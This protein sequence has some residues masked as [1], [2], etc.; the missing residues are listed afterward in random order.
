LRR[1]PIWWIICPVIRKANNG[2]VWYEFEELKDQGVTQAFLTRLGGASAPPFD[3]L[4]LGHTVGDDLAAVEENHDRAFAAL[5]LR[6]E[7]I[8][9]PYQV[10]GTHVR[11]VNQAHT[12]T[13]QPATDGLLTATPGVALLLRF[14]DCVPILLFDPKQ[15]AAAM[16]HSGWKST[17]GNIAAAAVEAFAR[18]AESKP[19]DLWAGV[20][21]AIGPC[22]YEVGEEMADTI[23]QISPE[24][25]EALQRRD[26]G[27]YLDLPGLVQAQLAEAGVKQVVMSGICT[28]CHTEEWF[29]HRAENGRTGRFGALVMLE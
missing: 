11:L 29:S 20:G 21:P 10:H 2:V 4:N 19:E 17:A 9:S 12:G 7:Q 8:V 13:T 23:S 28:A 27:L 5:G 24:G 6:R 25:I 3:T 18:H 14:A 16:V 26:G 1:I 15:R 22:C